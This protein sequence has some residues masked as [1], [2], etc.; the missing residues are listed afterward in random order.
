MW[1]VRNVPQGSSRPAPRST[2][3]TLSAGG[4]VLAFQIG[5][6]QGPSCC[7]A[8]AE[9]PS[10]HLWDCRPGACP[11]G[12]HP[13]AWSGLALSRGFGGNRENGTF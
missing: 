3:P 5:K 2:Q 7:L 10:S 12:G 1:G 6:N 9:G 8:G 4:W 11:A 13:G